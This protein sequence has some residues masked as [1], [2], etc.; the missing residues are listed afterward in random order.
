[1]RN[2][3]VRLNEVQKKMVNKFLSQ[4]LRIA[5]DL[6]QTGVDLMRQN[7]HRRHPDAEEL[8][9]QSLLNEW[10][11]TRPGAQQGDCPG[12]P[13]VCKHLPINQSI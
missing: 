6:H 5:L 2:K 8:E 13:Y 10:L 9:I 3:I 7:L 1:M 4:K 11:Q 12:R